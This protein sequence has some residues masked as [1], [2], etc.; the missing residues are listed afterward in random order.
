M[1]TFTYLAYGSNMLTGRLRARC[2]SAA[3]IGAGSLHGYAL[4]FCKRS[5]DFSGKASL[6]SAPG[7][8]VHGVLFAIDLAERHRLDQAE[9]PGYRR[10]EGMR[11]LVAGSGKPVTACA[12]VVTEEATDHALLPYD[13]YRAL[14]LAGAA[15]HGLPPD[16]VGF[17]SGHGFRTD[18][19]LER[20]SR[21][22]A[23][24]VL[25]AIG[26]E[27]GLAYPNCMADSSPG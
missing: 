23:L 6:V 27:H 22:E 19:E 17:L 8:V 14:I 5:V 25:D 15:Q 10:V 21:L 7:A 3:P 16:Y 18:C 2:P 26:C 24:R 12:Y 9:G 13:W 11:V 1:R 4:A 20:P